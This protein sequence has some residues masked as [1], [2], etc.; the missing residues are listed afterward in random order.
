VPADRPGDRVRA[1]TAAL[2]LLFGWCG[3]RRRIRG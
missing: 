2:L 3:A 1:A